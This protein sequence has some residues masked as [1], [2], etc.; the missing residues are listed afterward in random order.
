MF[1]LDGCP[2]DFV[3]TVYCLGYGEPDLLVYPVQGNSSTPQFWKVFF[4]CIHRITDFRSFA[5]VQ[6]SGC[7]SLLERLENKISLLRSMQKRGIWL[8]DASVVALKGDERQVFRQTAL[9]ASWREY[10]WPLLSEI[11]PACVI[12]I[13]RRFGDVLGRRLS[14]LPLYNEVFAQP[15]A[16]LS[17]EEHMRQYIRYYELC[18]DYAHSSSF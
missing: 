4:A 12:M 13:G 15:Q 18:R 16:Q 11:K 2:E 17:A 10:L 14:E 7:P 6:K 3:R 1:G 5:P 8:L 9:D